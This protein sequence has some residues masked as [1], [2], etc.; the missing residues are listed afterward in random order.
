MIQILVAA[1]IV[2]DPTTPLDLA[3]RELAR[4]DGEARNVRLEVVPDRR[5]EAFRIEIK[6]GKTRIVASDEV[7]ALYG[8]YEYAEQIRRRGRATATAKEPFLPERGMNLFLTLPWNTQKNDT[9][10][11]VAALTD[12]A[13]W[14]FHD[15]DYWRSLFDL[16]A[17][18]RLNWLDIHGTWDISVTDAPNLYGYF[19]TSPSFPRV[20]VPDPVK[21]A[22]MK[23]LNRV[24][25]L[26]HAHGIRVSLM[27][28]QAGL[29]I[30]HNP[31]PPYEA[32]E[33]NIYTYTREVVEQMIRRAPGLDAIGFRIGESGKGEAF[34]HC[35]NMKR[36]EKD[37]KKSQEER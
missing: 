5:R 13:R 17:R 18:S 12:P 9:D 15:D 2:V 36:E 24:I 29:K 11:D 34:F 10:Y 14:W 25:A 31:T 30:P 8:A 21:E 1:F 23:Q 26:A 16:M 28:Y 6:G 22:N 33:A 20:G 7:G 19:V 32:T 3:R 4:L 35:Y 27:A 37:K